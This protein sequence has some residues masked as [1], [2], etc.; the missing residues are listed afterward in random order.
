MDFTYLL[1][2]FLVVCWTLNPFLKKNAYSKLQTQESLIVNHVLCTAI[3]FI[4]FA[5]LVYNH[6]CDITCIKKLDKKEL[7]FAALGA[8]T[9]VL[10]SLTLLN[11][12]KENQASDII[13]YIQPLV[14]ISTLIIGYF[15]FNE[16]IT[17]NKIIGISLIVTGLFVL[18]RK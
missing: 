18:S 9:T 1:I 13:P 15:A 17:K 6:K 14:I 3:I 2:L 4:Y 10:A 11:L 12:L 7:L 16:T 5:Y 8:F